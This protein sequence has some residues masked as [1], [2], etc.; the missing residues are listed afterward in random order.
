MA[1]MF[2][3]SIS[4]TLI[5]EKLIITG[6]RSV[7]MSELSTVQPKPW[8]ERLQRL[9]PHGRALALCA[10]RVLAVLL[11]Y[12]VFRPAPPPL[13]NREVKD[14]IAQVMASATPLWPSW[15]SRPLPTKSC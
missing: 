2:G 11:L 4:F 10:A 8:R 13:T 3:M 15:F 5:S 12:S 6:L 1:D 14:T 9:R 7:K